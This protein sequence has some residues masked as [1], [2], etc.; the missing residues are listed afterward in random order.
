MSIDTETLKLINYF[1]GLDDAEL[2]FIKGYIIEKKVEKG[3]M[4]LREG[5]WSD[6]LFFV[7]SGFV[8]VYKTSIGGR[9]QILHIAPPGDSLNDVSTF[10]GGP[11]SA[12]M[13]AITP[14]HYYAIR[15]DNLR[16]I[17]RDPPRICANIIKSLANRI[18]RDA[19]LVGELSTTQTLARLA[20]L[21]LGKYAGEDAT[22]GLSLN[23]QDMANL[24]GASREVVNRALKTME[25]K[26]A[27]NLYRHRVIVADRRILSELAKDVV[28]N[29]APEYLK[30]EEKSL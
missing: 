14:V 19:Q 7:V 15:K 4:I 5:E 18:R 8:K 17:L 20:K 25:E 10:D 3:T 28:D 24:I 26:G 13:L 11:S 23:Q 6:F 1:T 2:E 29:A 22:A 30:S 12:S 27:I 21:F 16:I 9:E